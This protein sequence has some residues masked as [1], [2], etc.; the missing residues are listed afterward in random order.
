MDEER[1]RVERDHYNVPAE[2]KKNF[3]YRLMKQNEIPSWFI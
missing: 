2:V 1:Y 3:N